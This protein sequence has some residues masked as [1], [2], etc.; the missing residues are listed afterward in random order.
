MRGRTPFACLLVFSVVLIGALM[1]PAKALASPFEAK[2]HVLPFNYT[3]AIVVECNGYFGIVDSGE[4]DS[5]PDGSDPRYPLREGTIIGGGVEDKVIPY[6]WKIGVRPGNLDFYIGT[7]PHS[8]HIGSASQIIQ[9]FKPSRIYTPSYDDSYITD[10]DHLWDNQYV[11]DRLI[12]A[13]HEAEGEYGAQLIQ[14]FTYLN[15]SFMLGGA[16]IQLYNTGTDYQTTGVFD[17]NCFSLGVKVTVGIHS[18]FLAGDINNYTGVEDE[19]ASQVG[20]VDFLKMGHHGCSGSNTTAYLDALSPLYVFQTGKYSILPAQTAQSLANLGLRYASADDVCA[21]G[22]DAYV[23]T[24]AATGVTTN[25]DYSKPRVY[26]SEEA[27]A[28]RCYQGGLP[29]ASFTGWIRGDDGWLWFD[30]LSEPVLSSW[31]SDGGAWYYVGAD[32]LMCSGWKRIGS[33]WYYFDASGAMATGWRQVDGS[34]SYFAPSGQM[35][36]GWVL[37]H[38]SWYWLGVSGEMRTGWQ[39]VDGTWYFFAPSGAMRTGWQLIGNS[40]YFL[41]GSGAMATGWQKVAGEWYWLGSDGAMVTGWEMIGGLWYHFSGS[42]QMSTGWLDLDGSWYY[43]GTDG[44]MVMG[45][46]WIDGVEYQFGPTG[47]LLGA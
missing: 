24:L 14:N 46:E 16:F 20:S 43:L 4:D 42:G 5:Y 34:W 19:L 1:L 15:R 10:E 28:Y 3:D 23:V 17:A 26:Y 38:S 33:S 32:G 45:T 21:D 39:R 13:A 18:T 37:D 41:G 8:D 30:R 9:M 12:E 11:Y 44:A 40:W 22:I 36:T 7:H 31:V 47:A 2:I 29:N 6:L 27:G 35:Q 25:F